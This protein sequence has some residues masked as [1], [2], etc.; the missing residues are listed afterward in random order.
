MKK[1][2]VLPLLAVVLAGCAS[3]QQKIDVAT[4]VYKTATETTVP[5]DVVIPTATTFG[6]LKAAAKNF[7]A[8][9]IQ[10]KMV[11]AICSAATRRIVIKA[12]SA[13]T[14]ARDQMEASVDAGQPALASIY[15]VL[16]AAVNDL[17]A[18]PAS[19]LQ[20]SGSTQ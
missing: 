17:K 7:G 10:K 15:N 2:L 1:F 19:S 9:C 8:Y 4:G 11:P 14:R 3:L 13:G 18:S 5:A 6:I 20:F 16:V 12:V